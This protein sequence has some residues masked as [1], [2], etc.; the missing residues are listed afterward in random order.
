[1]EGIAA[2]KDFLHRIGT[3]TSLQQTNITSEDFAPIIADVVKVS[4]N[5]EGTLYSNPPATRQDIK[6]VLELAY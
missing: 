1:L 3:P 4:F 2:F 5:A 6:Q